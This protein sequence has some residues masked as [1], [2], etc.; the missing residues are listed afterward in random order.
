VAGAPSVGS[1]AEQLE[2]NTARVMAE[3]ATARGRSAVRI[4][5]AEASARAVSGP[6]VGDRSELLR[7]WPV[8]TNTRLETQQ[9]KR[10]R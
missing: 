3:Y 7:Q 6:G 2:T 10:L 1:D 5:S 9:A 8:W 4:V